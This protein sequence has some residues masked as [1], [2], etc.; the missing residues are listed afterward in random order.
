MPGGRLKGRLASF[1]VVDH[2]DPKIDIS[3]MVHT[4]AFRSVDRGA[5]ARLRTDQ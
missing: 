3:A 5:D 4:A 1:T 2:D